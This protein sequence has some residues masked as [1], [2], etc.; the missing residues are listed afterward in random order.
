MQSIF[1]YAAGAGIPLPMPEDPAALVRWGGVFYVFP[2]YFILPQYGNALIYR[3]RPDGDDPEACYFE[4]WSVTIP[5]ASEPRVKPTFGGVF[6]PD[7]TDAWPQIPLQDFSNIARQQ[8]GLH[9]QG[10]RALRLAEQYEGGI[11]NMHQEIDRYLSR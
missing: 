7:D 10:F 9:S 5:P 1:A 3:S 4:L 6:A 11:S 2:N 8:R